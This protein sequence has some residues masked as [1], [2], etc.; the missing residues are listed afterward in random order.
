MAENNSKSWQFNRQINVSTLIQLVLLA[1]L[2]VGCWVNLQRQLDLLQHDVRIL[3][4]SQ[5]SFERNLESLSAKSI[6]YEYRIRAIE[7]HIPTASIAEGC[8]KP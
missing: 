2:I 4:Q 5:K 1:V 6:S 3:L 8:L 7:K